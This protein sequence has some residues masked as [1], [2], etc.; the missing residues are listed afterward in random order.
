M[1]PERYIGKKINPE[2]V[3]WS[4]ES[5]GYSMISFNDSKS[6]V[7]ICPN[8]HENSF[9]WYYWQR[10]RRCKKCHQESRKIQSS[11]HSPQQ[12]IEFGINNS[13]SRRSFNHEKSPEDFLEEAR[14][15]FQE[16]GYILL[17]SKYVHAESPLGFVCP[18]GH[19]HQISLTRWKTGQRCGECYR[20]NRGN[21][22]EEIKQMFEKELYVLKSTNY[23][24]AKTPLEFICP[25][26]HN[27]QITLD[28]WKK[29]RRCGECYRLKIPPLV[30]PIV[31]SNKVKVI[32]LS[33]ETLTSIE[34]Y[35]KEVG[36]NPNLAKESLYLKIIDAEEDVV[37][38]IEKR[39]GIKF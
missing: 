26:G 11:D 29:G 19:N 36:K 17:S 7:S 31:Y 15:L 38:E 4:F 30:P 33:P 14:F 16:E 5:Q 39:L 23:T 6:I 25:S 2:Y 32:A 10:G 21:S 1:L 20:K 8:G 9:S 27:H 18:N 34:E 35:K 12:R 13:K 22:F 28:N 3:R 24:N 37:L